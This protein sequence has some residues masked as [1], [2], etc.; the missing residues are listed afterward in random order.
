MRK[1]TYELW[2]MTYD[3]SCH[4]VWGKATKIKITWD[5]RQASK[6]VV[7]FLVSSTLK[8]EKKEV[9]FR[10]CKMAIFWTKLCKIR[11][12]IVLLKVQ[13]ATLIQLMEKL[14]KNNKLFTIK[15]KLMVQHNTQKVDEVDGYVESTQKYRES[16]RNH[17][18]ALL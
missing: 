5:H 10:L 13:S 3:T 6:T 9:I 15:M 4:T 11:F 2:H 16:P 12:W 14:Q 7:K 18:F 17:I 8:N 1:V